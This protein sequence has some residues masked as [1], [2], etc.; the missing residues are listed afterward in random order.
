MLRGFS[1]LGFQTL[2]ETDNGNILIAFIPNGFFYKI[3][4]YK[5]FK[6]TIIF[7]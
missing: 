2:G 7:L 1:D 3:L 4:E 5:A 6:E